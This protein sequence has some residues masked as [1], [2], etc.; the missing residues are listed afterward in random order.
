[1]IVTDTAG[2][3]RDLALRGITKRFSGYTAVD[4]LDLHVPAGS[5]FALLGPSGCGKSTTLRMIAGLEHPTEGRVL[6]GE[7]DV[8]GSKAH[9]REVNTVFQSYALFPHLSVLEN[10]AFGL[11][12]RKVP[13]AL[14]RA[15]T[16]LDLVELGH[17]AQ[18]RPAQ[19]SGG[20]QQ[21]VALARAIVNEPHVLLLDEPL[22]ALDMKLR[23][24]MQTELKHIQEEIGITFIHVTHDQEEALTMADTVAVMNAGRIEQIGPPGELYDLPRTAFVANFLG[25][26]NLFEAEVLGDAPS[27][28]GKLTIRFGETSCTLAAERAV[29]HAGTIVVGIRP[30]KILISRTGERP[31]GDRADWTRVT[32]GRVS[33]A[34]YTGVSTEYEVEL[35]AAGTLT[36]FSQNLHTEVISAGTEVDLW[37]DDRN[38]FGL[39]G[40]SDTGAGVGEL[41]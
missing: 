7:E 37:W 11:K 14:G 12:R 23:R 15:G 38:L 39:A 22:G 6:I 26:S 30:E 17:L 27:A 36:V 10:V 16:I 28:P 20:Q 18:R 3:G 40:G 33:S 4:D 9:Q 24:Q 19:L 32:G 25:K 2:T 34:A 29:Q 13:D 8:T 31:P 21:R 5:F 41:R 1:M 35:P